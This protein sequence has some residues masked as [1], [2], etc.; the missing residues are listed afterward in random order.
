MTFELFG[1][2]QLIVVVLLP[3]S[4]LFCF[5]LTAL[6]SVAYSSRQQFSV[7]HSI[8]S[9]L[10]DQ[11]PKAKLVSCW[12]V[13]YF[14]QKFRSW[15]K[16]KQWAERCQITQMSSVNSVWV[17]HHK[18]RLSHYIWPIVTT[19]IL[20]SVALICYLTNRWHLLPEKTVF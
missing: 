17:F 13:K 6:I 8:L 10:P 5:S 12:R 9:A 16:P 2:F 20:I 1:I 15:W 14:P 4:L 18:Q 3:V 19:Q 11:H 7:K